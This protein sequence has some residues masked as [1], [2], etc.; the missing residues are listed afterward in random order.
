MAKR[1]HGGEEIDRSVYAT[2]YT[3]FTVKRKPSPAVILVRIAMI[4]LYIGI[5]VG[6]FCIPNMWWLGSLTFLMAAIVW[7][8]TWPF[9]IIEFEYTLSSGDLRFEK[10][11]GQRKR[12]T[13]LEKKIKDMK[14]IAPYTE[15]HKSKYPVKGKTYD[16]RAS[17]K[18]TDD[19]YFAIFDENGQDSAVLFQCTNKALKIFKSY[20]KENTVM[21][22]TLR[23]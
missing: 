19:V 20:N 13:V 7:Y 6:V 21:V 22:D 14:I 16:F 9:T 2:N 12:V 15:E 17:D 11:F 23:Y 10:N 4:I 1:T 5:P 18:Q 8:F 3:E